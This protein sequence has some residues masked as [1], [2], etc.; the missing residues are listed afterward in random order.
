MKLIESRDF[1]APIASA[2]RIS[3]KRTTILDKK[4]EI[5]GLDHLLEHKRKLRKLWQE[6]MDL[7]CKMAVN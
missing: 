5:P 6:T 3:T 1:A 7:A 4:Y 2:Y